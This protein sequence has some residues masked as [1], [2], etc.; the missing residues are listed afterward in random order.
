MKW[1]K[2]TKFIEYIYIYILN[3]FKYIKIKV[4][5]KTTFILILLILSQELYIIS[6]NWILFMN[7]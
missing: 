3:F 2:L 1:L 7:K 6:C 5:N 4:K